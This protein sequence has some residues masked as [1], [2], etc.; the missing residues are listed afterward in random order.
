MEMEV[1]AVLIQT[2]GKVCGYLRPS[3]RAYICNGFK[4]LTRLLYALAADCS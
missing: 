1:G 2:L 3:E 4:I